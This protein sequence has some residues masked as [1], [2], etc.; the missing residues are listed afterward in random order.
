M[1]TIQKYEAYST[2]EAME[3]RDKYQSKFYSQALF[4]FP[5]RIRVKYCPADLKSQFPWLKI[6]DNSISLFLTGTNMRST[7]RL[8]N[9]K[10]RWFQ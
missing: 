3:L 7:G 6:K 2:Q 1:K 5:E 10:N 9:M 4:F 8:G